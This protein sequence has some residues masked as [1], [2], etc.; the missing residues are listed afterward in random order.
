VAV[1]VV[2]YLTSTLMRSPVWQARGRR[3]TDARRGACLPPIWHFAEAVDR[4]SRAV[5]KS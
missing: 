2:V 4:G 5:E 3:R 1:A